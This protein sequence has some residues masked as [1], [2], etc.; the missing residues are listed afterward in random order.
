[1]EVLRIT[2]EQEDDTLPV[3]A[4]VFIKIFFRKHFPNSGHTEVDYVAYNHKIFH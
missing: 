4:R 1:M 2:M 3:I